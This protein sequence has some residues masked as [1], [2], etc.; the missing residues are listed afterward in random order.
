MTLHSLIQIRRSILLAP[1]AALL[2]SAC[3]V[4]SVV[5]NW[6]TDKP[7]SN[8]PDKVTLSLYCLMH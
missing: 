8:N 2:L 3:S 4:T 6:K 5:D 1:L 7:V